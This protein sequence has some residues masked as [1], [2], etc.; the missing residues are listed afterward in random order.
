MGARLRATRPASVPF[1]FAIV[2]TGALACSGGAPTPAANPRTA[3]GE[4]Q[5]QDAFDSTP[6]LLIAVFPLAL[7][8]DRVYGPLL[9][10]AIELARERSRVVAETRAL[11]A[12]VEVV[13]PQ[14]LNKKA[15]SALE[16][17][18]IATS[19]ADPRE[20]LLRRARQE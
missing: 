5:W 16:D 7:R 18:R 3:T 10:R 13:V 4:A 20:E 12:T 8:S 19:E 11:L 9:R 2:L 6:E 17:L 14:D 1:A 15:R